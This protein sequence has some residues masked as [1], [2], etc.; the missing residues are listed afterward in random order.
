MPKSSYNV[1][2]IMKNRTKAYINER[3]SK[4]INIKKIL[5]SLFLKPPFVGEFVFA[6]LLL[7]AWIWTLINMP[8]LINLGTQ[9]VSCMTDDEIEQYKTDMVE[10]IISEL[11]S[12]GLTLSNLRLSEEFLKN[13][14]IV[15]LLKTSGDGS[16]PGKNYVYLNNGSGI[17]FTKNATERY[18]YLDNL[19]DSRQVD[20]SS[21]YIQVSR[22]TQRW[23]A[24]QERLK[25][26][27]KTQGSPISKND[28]SD[29]YESEDEEVKDGY[30]RTVGESDE[31][32]N[33]ALSNILD[34][35]LIKTSIPLYLYSAT[36]NRELCEK[37]IQDS[38]FDSEIIL[39]SYNCTALSSGI[40][41]AVE[42]KRKF[43]FYYNDEE[44]KNEASYII[45]KI[46]NG[47]YNVDYSSN[48]ITA[49]RQVKENRST[50][51]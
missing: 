50:S 49:Y 34:P 35:F 39:D 8:S 6:I 9:A 1:L 11:G 17:E 14:A 19:D 3:K 22:T 31:S 27:G 29:D 15:S 46:K 28:L 20:Y 41:E 51:I 38:V 16:K 44:G 33:I 48:T 43:V 47:D 2:D 37:F 12:R 32:V 7:A 30:F 23:N 4:K 18:Y 24:T 25:D 21:A 45:N 36:N 13:I 42:I 5:K 26:Y 10:C 40:P